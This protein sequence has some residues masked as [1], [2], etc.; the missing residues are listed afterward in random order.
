M[1]AVTFWVTSTSVV[2]ALLQISHLSMAFWDLPDVL[3]VAQAVKA[4]ALSLVS[5]KALSSCS[6]Q[7]P[8]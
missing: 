5:V 3:M 6:Y 2:R 4:F 8:D 1:V 7:F